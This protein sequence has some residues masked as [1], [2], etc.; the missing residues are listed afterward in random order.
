MEPR[1]PKAPPDPA[2]AREMATAR[3]SLA[4]TLDSVA[5]GLTGLKTVDA[6]LV[7]AINQAN[8]APLTRDT[9][10]RRDYGALSAPAPDERRR[11]ASINA[12]AA[13][14][15]LPFETARRH[16]HQ[17][18]AQGVCV[19]QGRGVIIPEAYLTSPAY[20]QDVM[21]LAERL[22][23]LYWDLRAEGLL[24]DLPPSEFPL[25]AGGAPIR[26]AARLLADFLLRSTEALARRAPDVISA[27]ILLAIFCES[28]RSTK[29]VSVA[30]IARRLHM[31]PETVRRRT[32]ELVAHG[33]CIRQGQRFLV[34]EPWQAE[35]AWRALFRDSANSLNRLMA[36]L[37][38][39]GIIDAWERMD[40]ARLA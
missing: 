40:A 14:L 20:L 12:I 17:L 2:I 25:E 18:E 22:R 26:A 39:R 37:A 30:D 29:G 5:Q 31:A 19:S 7:L 13:S 4:F 11:P 33:L 28:E 10:A 35:P 24:D 1:T 9:K 6:L 23:R 27:F 32:T 8:I 21:A 34:P 15:H 38:E 3:L 16:V 36:A